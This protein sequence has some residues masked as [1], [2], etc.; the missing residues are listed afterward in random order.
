MALPKEEKLRQLRDP[1][2]R[3]AWDRLAQSQEGPVRAIANWGSYVLLETFSPNT[4]Q[5]QGKVVA[6]VA[7]ELGCSAWEA[8]VDIVVADELRTVIATQDRGQDAATWRRR[9]EVWRDPR[10]VVGASDAGAH[11]DMIDSFSFTTTL[12]AKAVRE[13][14]LVTV[15]EAVHHLTL[16]PA[17]LYGLRGR[18]FLDVGAFAD[19]VVFDPDAVGPE[20]VHTRFDLPG[21]AARV[22]GGAQGIHHVLVNGVPCVEGSKLLAAR[23]GTL[24]RSGRDTATVTAQS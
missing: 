17:E 3:A 4:K 19:V 18:G 2:E 12:L 7:A 23:P 24:L 20:P 8:L 21:G 6:E 15:E 22:Y 5:H 10:A 13:H 1:D 9:V 16:R 14:G 11:L